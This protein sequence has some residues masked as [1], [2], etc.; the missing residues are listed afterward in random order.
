M[1]R[2]E[3]WPD[4]G[5][6]LL[7]SEGTPVAIDALGLPAD[8]VDAIRE[9]LRSYAD[10][11]LE[12]GSIDEAWVAEGRRYFRELRSLLLPS[13]IE[14]FDWEGYWD[15]EPDAPSFPNVSSS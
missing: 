7:H 5:L 14:L 11:K 12:T 4:Y 15:S 8:V 2:I 6:A 10:E 1:R 3:F 13:G 9:W